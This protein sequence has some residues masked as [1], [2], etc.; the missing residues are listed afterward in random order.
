[1]TNTQKNIEENRN[2]L[3]GFTILRFSHASDSGGGVEQLIED[4][5]RTLLNR[6]KLNI[7]RMYLSDD[8]GNVKERIEKIGKGTLVKIPLNIGHAAFQT[9]AD[10][11]KTKEP[12]L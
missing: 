12:H 4:L 8:I 7:L 6:N 10:R 3:D 5:D 1:M 11:Q 2:L 9:D